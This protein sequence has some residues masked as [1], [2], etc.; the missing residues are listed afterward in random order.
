MEAVIFIGIQGAG[1]TTFYGER[2]SETHVRISLDLLKTRHREQAFLQTCLH[3]GQAF[4]IDNTNVK[5]AERA[6]YIDRAKAAGFQVTGYFFETSLRDALRRN[7]LRSGRAVVPVPGVIGTLK[8]LQPPSLEEGFDELHIVSRDEQD[9]FVVTSH[10]G[11][12]EAGGPAGEKMH[13]RIA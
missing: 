9:Q 1:K 6:L 13:A 2:F 12:G 10:P 4:V 7:K 5:T 3:T 8:R 11:A